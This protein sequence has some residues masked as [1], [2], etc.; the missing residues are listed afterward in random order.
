MRNIMSKITTESW[1][2]RAKEVHGHKFGYDKVEYTKYDGKVEVYCNECEQYF[3]TPAC[4]HLKGTGCNLCSSRKNARTNQVSEEEFIRRARDKHGDVYDYSHLGYVSYTK[5]VTVVCPSH[6]KFSVYPHSHVKHKCKLCASEDSKLPLDEWKKE[7]TIIH[8]GKYTY[9]NV[10]Y[11]FVTDYVSVTCPIHGDFS[12]VA[13]KHK[14]QGVRLIHVFDADDMEKVKS[15]IRSIVVNSE[16]RLYARQCNV[17]EIDSNVFSEFCDRYHLQSS[18]NTNIRYGL[19]YKEEL[20]SVMSFAKSRTSKYAWELNRYC[21]KSDVQVVA[22]ASKLLSAFRKNNDGSIV[23]YA[24]RRWSVGNVYDKL[25][26][27]LS[28]ISPPTY[29]YFKNGR[30]MHKS[31]FKRSDIERR[32]D[33]EFDSNLS[34]VDNMYNN[35][36]MR[37]WDCG[38]KVYVLK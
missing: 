9:G 18:C 10:S 29:W 26:F 11:E 20:V 2:M 4:N 37:I 21:V 33:L 8:K 1:I 23:S 3:T 16:R 7:C 12:V 19:F 35:G 5:K 32:V 6:G 34:E 15:F 22:G 31:G 17:S 38:L 27:E 24:N 13:A 25:G 30:L 14:N 28:H 36:Y